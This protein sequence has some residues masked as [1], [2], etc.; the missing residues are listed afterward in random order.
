MSWFTEIAG[1]AE[2]LLNRVDQTA[3]T[4]LQNKNKTSPFNS[5]DQYLKSGPSDENYRT[6]FS[7]TSALSSPQRNKVSKSTRSLE[8]KSFYNPNMPTARKKPESDDEK[9]LMFLN[10]NETLSEQQKSEN[11]LKTANKPSE[12]LPT[13][14]EIDSSVKESKIYFL[15]ICYSLNFVL[16]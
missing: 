1:K 2:D 13:V 16:L 5:D 3:A 10:S 6:S 8:N 4:A 7:S 14:S 12:L 11:L 15:Y 9:L